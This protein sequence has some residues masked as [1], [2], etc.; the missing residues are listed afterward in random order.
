MCLQHRC[1]QQVLDLRLLD[2]QGREVAALVDGVREAGRYAEALH[3]GDLR[4]GIYFVHMQAPGFQF[5]RRVVI[6]K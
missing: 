1:Q 2:V 5:A 6:V 3:A 4:A